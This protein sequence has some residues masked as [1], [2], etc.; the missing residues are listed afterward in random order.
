MKDLLLSLLLLFMPPQWTH[1]QVPI[2]P[3]E[4]VMQLKPAPLVGPVLKLQP[5]PTVAVVRPN[6]QRDELVEIMLDYQ[7]KLT[8][9]TATKYVKT[10]RAATEEYKIDPLWV[11]AMMWQES[12]FLNRTESGAGAVGL[13]QILPS[14][15]RGMGVD[16]ER[17]W[18]PEV[19]IKLGVKYLAGDLKRFGS[20]RLAT[21]AYNQGSTRVAKGTYRTWYYDGVKKHYAE[22]NRRI[23][24][25]S[26]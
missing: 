24:K 2:M 13:M 8:R 12:R 22:M 21:L 19:N 6:P 10:V 4:S 14:T 3:A 20:L 5:K 25:E 11:V 23:N 16:P 18:V 1:H 9:Q 15:A 17:L 7:P 26:V